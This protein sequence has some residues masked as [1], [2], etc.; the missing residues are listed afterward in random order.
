MTAVNKIKARGTATT[1]EPEHTTTGPTAPV[2]QPATPQTAP[3][4]PA[5]LLPAARFSVVQH[6]QTTGQPIT[7]DDL[8]LRLN[9]TPAVAETLITTIRDTNPARINGHIPTLTGG[10]R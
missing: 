8:A 3:V 1:P 10:A 5:H 4:V 7:A 2:E 6:E 9:I